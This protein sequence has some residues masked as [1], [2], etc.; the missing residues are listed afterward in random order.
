[1]VFIVFEGRNQVPVFIGSISGILRTKIGRYC[2]GQHCAGIQYQFFSDL[3]GSGAVLICCHRDISGFG[4]KQGVFR[5]LLRHG[6]FLAKYQVPVGL[7]EISLGTGS[8]ILKPCA[9][10]FPLCHDD[11]NNTCSGIKSNGISGIGIGC[12]GNTHSNT[13]FSVTQY[14][15]F[16]CGICSGK[17]HCA[18]QYPG[19]CGIVTSDAVDQC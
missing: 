15:G 2:T 19:R 3:N 6:R 12:G 14:P 5:K 16:G 4:K 7:P 17:A 18:F 10:H 11:T 1:M 13:I 9:G 8:R